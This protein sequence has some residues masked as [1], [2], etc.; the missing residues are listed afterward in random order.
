V[1]FPA[2]L[3]YRRNPGQLYLPAERLKSHHHISSFI[4]QRFHD[5]STRNLKADVSRLSFFRRNFESGPKE[6]FRTVELCWV[7]VRSVRFLPSARHQGDSN[8]LNNHQ[9]L[10]K[11]QQGCGLTRD[12]SG[13]LQLAVLLVIVLS[14]G[15]IVNVPR[16]RAQALEWVR[17]FSWDNT[18]PTGV[19]VTSNGIY[20]AGYTFG[21][22]PGFTNPGPGYPD[23]FIAK[24]DL[25]GSVVW[26]RQF[27]S[28]YTDKAL[29]VAAD[30]T[31]VYLAGVAGVLPGQTDYG[32]F[33]R[34]YDFDGNELWTRVFRTSGLTTATAISVGPSGVYVAGWTQGAFPGQT[35]LGDD[36]AFVRKYDVNGSEIWTREFGSSSLD[37]A[38]GISV[39]SSGVYVVGVTAGA[40]PGQTSSGLND[41]FVHQYYSNGTEGWTRQFGTNNYDAGYGVA[42]TSSDVYVVGVVNGALPG[43]VSSG[44]DDAF[45]RKYDIKGQEIW[46]RQFGA[47]SSGS[48]GVFSDNSGVYVTGSVSGALP[49]QNQTGLYDAFVRKYDPSGTE[50]WTH[51][52]GASAPNIIQGA[53]NSAAAISGD[54]TGVYV[55]GTTDGAFIGQNVNG[56]FQPFI[57]KFSLGLPVQSI[58]VNGFFTGAG[59]NPLPISSSGTATVNAVIVQGEVAAT[60]PGQ[61]LDWVNVT[62]T[63]HGPLN[64]LQLNATLPSDWVASPGTGAGAVHEFLV[65]TNGT[66]LVPTQNPG[67][68]LAS[69]TPERVSVSFRDINNTF[70]SPWTPGESILV[71][72]KLTYNLKGTAQLSTS[73]PRNYVALA[74]ASAFD[75]S[76]FTGERAN[77]SGASYLIVQV[78]ILGDVNGDGTVNIL[79]LVLVGQALGS[80]PS[81]PQWNPLADL[82]G[83][84]KIDVFDLAIVGATFGS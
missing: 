36:D 37:D 82:N 44:N 34:K 71:S 46:T 29:G 74:S 8:I 22:L 6:K 49:G 23:V 10:L 30:G 27:G 17:Q 55:T 51:Q 26:T 67:V 41:I 64:S 1:P 18:D 72:V 43:Q 69:G 31:G 63:G 38:E 21:S 33:V 45:V 50:I 84:G 24:I 48:A 25:S 15:G 62:N 57:A 60:N 56:F 35:W 14:V 39:S 68:A 16:V 28:P 80:R 61:I 73:F 42:A 5:I 19:A 12:K 7:E 58:A 65:L 4:P 3:F 77:G 81:D 20:I 52:F 76:S 2:V 47:G 66:A 53:I 9:R 70:N 78:K 11:T 79:D 32:A 40:L 75:N 13:Y 59:Q 54:S 83:D